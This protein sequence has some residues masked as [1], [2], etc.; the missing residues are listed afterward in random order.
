MPAPP[1]ESFAAELYGELRPLAWADEAHGWALAHL[2]AA[3]G[4]PFQDV[5]DLAR[6]AGA[7]VGW[8]LVLDPARAPSVDWLRWLSQLAGADVP[9]GADVTV[10]QARDAVETRGNR[11]R[12]GPEAMR[13]AARA[14]LEGNRTVYINERLGG[15]AYRIGAA[16]IDGETPDATATLAALTSQ[17][18]AGVVLEYGTVP[19]AGGMTW[20]ELD[21]RYATWAGAAAAF[22]TWADVLADN[23]TP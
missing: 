23:P 11:Q 2:C 21:V 4:R 6:D 12:G 3:L 1:L 17:K 13:A 5:E 10:E 20:T 15:S 14:T 22:P 18:P 8:S 19:G 9:V 7:A 16:T